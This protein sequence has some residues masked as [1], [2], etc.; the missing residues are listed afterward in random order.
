[1]KKIDING[2]TLVEVLVA[3]VIFMVISMTILPLYILV[4]AERKHLYDKRNIM[5]GLHDELQLWS[6]T[7]Q[8]SKTINKEISHRNVK[9]QFKHEHEW[10][11][12]CAYWTDVRSREQTECI[13]GVRQ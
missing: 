11:K 5:N 4:E 7:N 12:G 9:I 1:M 13:Y 3:M 6:L 10:L 2:F 8:L